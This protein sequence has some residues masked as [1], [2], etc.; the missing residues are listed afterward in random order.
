MVFIFFLSICVAGRVA[1]EWV[2]GPGCWGRPFH[3][4]GKYGAGVVQSR[5]IRSCGSYFA[6]AEPRRQDE[7]RSGSSCLH[8]C[9]CYVNSL[10]SR[11]C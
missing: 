9:A 6:L 11:R 8:D 10:F 2:S 1:D 3:L 7:G 4:I 5:A